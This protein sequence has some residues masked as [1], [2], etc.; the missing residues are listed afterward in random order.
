MLSLAGFPVT[1]VGFDG[2]HRALLSTSEPS[3]AE[4]AADRAVDRDI[5]SD[6]VNRV[7]LAHEAALDEAASRIHAEGFPGDLR[8]I[9]VPPQRVQ[10]EAGEILLRLHGPGPLPMLAE[11]VRSDATMDGL[12][13]FATGFVKQAKLVPVI[14]GAQ[15]P[16]AAHRMVRAYEAV[17]AA[18]LADGVAFETLDDALRDA[19]LQSGRFVSRGGRESW[20][21]RTLRQPDPEEIVARMLTALAGEGTRLVDEGSVRRTSD[22]DVICV[23]GLGFPRF[24]GGPMFW[25]QRNGLSVGALPRL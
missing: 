18:M 21:T 22:V 6:A 7:A 10:G 20:S 19:G 8:V 15:D 1:L 12:L 17:C 3:F 16:G 2:D 13:A 25:A 23:I 5:L 9:L 14:A 11:I 4:A 24:R